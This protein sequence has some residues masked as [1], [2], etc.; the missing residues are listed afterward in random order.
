[1]TLDA[2]EFLQRF[3]LH[4]LPRGLVRVRHYGLVA[5][6]AKRKLI[7]SCRRLLGVDQPDEPAAGDSTVA[8]ETWQELFQRLTGRDVTLCPKCQT[9]HLVRKESGSAISPPSTPPAVGRSP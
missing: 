7:A 6:G 8:A 2:P 3:L 4:V 1:M 5:N 9:G